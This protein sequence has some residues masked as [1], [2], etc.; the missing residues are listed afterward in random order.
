[1]LLI[2]AAERAGIKRFIASTWCYDF[3]G[4]VLGQHDS[5]DT[6]ILLKRHLEMSSSIKPTFILSGVLAEVFFSV[7]GR[8]SFSPQVHGVWDPQAKAM[9]IW[10][11]GDE[12]WHWTTERD[13]A[14]FAADIIGREGAEEGGFWEVCSGASTSWEL[15]AE[16]ERVR[17]RKVD[18]QV[19]GTV[20]ELRAN[21]VEARR[22]GS[23]QNMW[24]YIGWYYNLHTVDGTWTLKNLD[25]D[26]LATKTTTLEEFLEENPEV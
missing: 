9:E 10:G 20:E 17:G 1:M 19:K 3:R 15:A 12:V 21:A 8:V 4:L 14:H 13:A 22:Q 16:Y 7:P 24:G 11:T 26:K 18:V 6:Y 5:Y 25:N 2:R 23:A